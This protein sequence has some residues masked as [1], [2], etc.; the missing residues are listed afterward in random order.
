MYSLITLSSATMKLNGTLEHHESLLVTGSPH[1]RK[2]EGNLAWSPAI[3]GGFSS[4][5]VL[6]KFQREV[7]QGRIRVCLSVNPLKPEVAFETDLTL[8]QVLR[9]VSDATLW[10]KSVPRQNR[11]ATEPTLMLTRSLI[12]P[13]YSLITLSLKCCFASWIR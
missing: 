13:P 4:I 9:F 6:F 3:F 12:V 8:S 2:I 5:G 11:A 7:R 10:R 1:R